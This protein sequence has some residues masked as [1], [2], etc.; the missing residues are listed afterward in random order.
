MH[1]F[2]KF[3]LE[4]TL[5]SF[6]LLLFYFAP[7]FAGS[8]SAARMYP[9]NKVTIF[10]GENKVGVY[11]REAPLPE[12]YT[13]ATDGKCAVKMDEIYMVAEDKTSFSVAGSLYNRK[14]FLNK[15]TLYFRI[16]VMRHPISFITPAGNISAQTIILRSSSANSAL[17]GYLAVNNNRSELG[18]VDGGSMVVL[19]ADGQIT[20]SK[21]EKIMLAQAEM[22]I[23]PP[24]GDEPSKKETEQPTPAETQPSETPKD[25]QSMTRGT[26]IAMGV[27]GTVAA[28]G[29]V[30]ALGGGSG[31]SGSG[32]NGDV[33]PSNIQ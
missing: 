25:K 16:P 18:I 27:V 6:A 17:I 31:G 29:A 4:R 19:T 24:E 2:R 14:L 15:G 23:G 8:F 9:N 12:G 22:D 7:C 5:V 26:K 21:G 1:F 10:N 13:L 11:S 20:V 32:S 28:A 3:L 33:S 30:F